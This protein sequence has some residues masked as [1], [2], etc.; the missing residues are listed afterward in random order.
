MWSSED[1]ANLATAV[2]L[3]G[4]QTEEK[5]VIEFINKLEIVIEECIET[6]KELGRVIPEPEY[7]VTSG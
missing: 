4:C 2:E 1:N 6:A 5:T 3:P 7:Y